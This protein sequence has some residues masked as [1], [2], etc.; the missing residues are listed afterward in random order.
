MVMVVSQLSVYVAGDSVATMI[1]SGC[2]LYGRVI[3]LLFDFI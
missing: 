1:P 2:F 3:Q